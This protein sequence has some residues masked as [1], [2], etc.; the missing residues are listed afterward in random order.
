ML[1]SITPPCSIR[2][3][4]ETWDN[5][6]SLC[7]SEINT[8]ERAKRELSNFVT[9]EFIGFNDMLSTSGNMTKEKLFKIAVV[10]LTNDQVKHITLHELKFFLSQAFSM[11]YG[12]VYHGFG[13]D[14][15]LDWFE[16]YWEDREKEFENIRE[17]QHMEFT[18]NEKGTRTKPFNL[19]SVSGNATKDDLV[20]YQT[21][22]TILNDLKDKPQ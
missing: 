13:L 19:Q 4:V 15:L 11:Q 7:I 1:K 21:I 6:E 22:G 2:K 14:V 3:A 16:K 17:Q 20:D 9:G 8:D 12:K 18:G 10:F 5:R